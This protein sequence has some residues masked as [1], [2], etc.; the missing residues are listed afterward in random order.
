MGVS[1]TWE[2]VGPVEEHSFAH[3]SSLN[4]AIENAFGGLPRI[5][6]EDDIP[7]LEGISACGHPDIEDLIAAILEH[8]KVLVKSH[9]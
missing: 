8:E 6:M 4:S 3:G 7:K 1:F 5:F 9:W 2:I